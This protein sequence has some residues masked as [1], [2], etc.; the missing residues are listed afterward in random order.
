[1]T[2]LFIKAENWK[3]PKYPSAGERICNWN[4]GQQ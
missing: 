3:Q 2:A 1:M 4:T